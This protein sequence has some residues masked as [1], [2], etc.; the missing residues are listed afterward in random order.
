MS[1]YISDC[2]EKYKRLPRSL[3]DN[4]GSEDAVLK[5]KKLETQFDVDLKF[6]VL[7]I[8]IGELKMEGVAQY[9]QKE[10]KI[11]LGVAEEVKK[12]LSYLFL[13]L[14][15]DE[16][17]LDKIKDIFSNQLVSILKINDDFLLDKISQELY[18]KFFEDDA[19]KSEIVKLFRNN[20]EPLTSK[21]IIL[22]GKTS[23]PTIEN[24]IKDFIKKE[25]SSMFDNIVLSKFVANS[26]N[27]SKLNKDEKE[28]LRKL[29]V[30][31]R[32]INFF[33]ESLDNVL[34]NKKEIIPFEN[35][36]AAKIQES[37]KIE[38]PKT[39]VADDKEKE[40]LEM[41]K[42]YPAGSLERKAVEEEI[43]KLNKE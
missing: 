15:V 16:I 32:M 3:R 35:K 30:L 1:K 40:L 41:A 6:V 33:P 4:I 9:L 22:E 39:H 25:G 11:D 7:L 20:Q 37:I 36:E 43:R 28:L 26:T 19:Y 24:W 14:V 29:L 42:K 2:L 8:V 34:K 23:H 12:S 18:V 21:E 17:D 38:L 13:D 10:Q 5:I 31:Y 27:A